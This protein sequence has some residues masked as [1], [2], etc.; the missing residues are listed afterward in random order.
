M[1]LF[2]LNHIMLSSLHSF[3]LQS[4]PVLLVYRRTQ[5]RLDPDALI[6]LTTTEPESEPGQAEPQAPS[7]QG[8]G[9]GGEGDIGAAGRE[10]GE[11]QG[12]QGQGQ[13]QGG[14]PGP[15]PPALPAAVNVDYDTLPL[16]SSVYERQLRE[17]KQVR[18]GEG[19]V[20]SGKGGGV[21]R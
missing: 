10:A 12:D 5:P 20:F 17:K 3:I 4:V 2:C 7:A 15:R 21:E 1:S 9:G 8:T 14:V 16:D 18:R 19:G 11:G 13:G 6:E